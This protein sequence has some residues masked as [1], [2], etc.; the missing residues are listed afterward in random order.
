M[1]DG[2]E[3][4]RR[5]VDAM[6]GEIS[7]VLRVGG[8]YVCISLAQEHILA[9]VLDYFPSRGWMVRVHKLTDADEDKEQTSYF[10]VFVFVFTKFKKMANM[11]KVLEMC[12]Y[13]DDKVTRVADEGEIVAAVH[14]LQQYA[15]VRQ[16]LH[17]RSHVGEQM[18]LQLHAA[19]SA[20]TPRYTLHVVDRPVA[21]GDAAFA[22]FIVPQGRATEWMFGSDAGRLQ[23]AKQCGFRRVIVTTL[24]RD[25]HYE[26]LEAIKAELSAKVLELAPAG[27]P[28]NTQVPFLSVGADIG[29]RT[30]V[31][32]GHSELSGDF[33]VEDV[34]TD[35][36]LFRRLVF[37]SNQN[38]VQSEAKLVAVSKNNKKKRKSSGKLSIDTSYLSCQHHHYMV[39]GIAFVDAISADEKMEA[40]VVGLGG[41]ALAMYLQQYCEVAVEAVELDPTILDV[42][43]RFYGFTMSETLRVEVCDGLDYIRKLSKEGSKKH[44]VLLDVDSKDSS[45]GMSCPPASFV[46]REF[47]QTIYNVLHAKNG[48]LVLNLVCR[49]EAL[50]S[51]LIETVSAIFPLV[52]TARVPEEVNEIVYACRRDAAT[53]QRPLP[54]ALERVNAAAT[55]NG[56]RE[57]LTDVA[58]LLDNL[59][60]HGA[61]A[62]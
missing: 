14:E 46:E 52:Y 27:M 9:K 37:L 55:R 12:M 43:V 21:A 62:T 1:T 48:V 33:V 15:L 30:T 13:D 34:E 50:R 31:H 35:A 26:G 17:T 61:R 29:R 36:G 49:E 11:T 2:S 20:Q 58:E 47:L 7:R 59:T 10:P 6:F 5:R 53:T 56:A 24:H 60:L 45:V 28:A 16:Q 25:Q 42:A 18:S 23:L 39:S 41:G 44:M 4:V 22:I 51:L 57:K 32:Q 54:A 3:A 40:V 38:V 19:A 8:R